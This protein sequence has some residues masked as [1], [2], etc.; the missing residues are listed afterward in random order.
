MVL[1]IMMVLLLFVS[2]QVLAQTPGAWYPEFEI[3]FYSNVT[4]SNSGGLY[5][6]MYYSWPQKSQLHYYSMGSAVCLNYGI[7]Y[8]DCF[9]LWNAQGMYHGVADGDCC[10]EKPGAQPP[11]PSWPQDSGP[12]FKGEVT[13]SY[14]GL[15]GNKYTFSAIP[16]TYVETLNQLPLFLSGPTEAEDLHYITTSM[17]TSPVDP[18][19][20]E[21]P[22]GGCRS[23]C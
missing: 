4:A 1:L 19:Y 12:T 13:D 3:Q 22:A 5:G 2:A 7:M 17:Y 8:D 21:L 23:S 6:K 18:Y 9:R 10:L 16:N 15:K 11:S 14:S 20:F